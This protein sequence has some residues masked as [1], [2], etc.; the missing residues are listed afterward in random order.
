[1]SV[2]ISYSHDSIE[3]CDKVLNFSNKLR[4]E[5]IDTILDQ[6]EDAPEEG[7]PRWTETKIEDSDFVIIFVSEGYFK[8]I[9]NQ[10]EVNQG[11]GVKWEGNVIYQ[12]LYNNGNYNNKFIPVV[13]NDDDYMFIPKPLQ[14]NTFYNISTENGYNNLYWRLRNIH[15]NEKP[16]LGEL[17]P[18]P[19][20]K[21]KTQFSPTVTESQSNDIQPDFS[22]EQQ[23]L[24]HW[25][26]E[27][28]CK[29]GP[30]DTSIERA[31]A[32]TCEGLLAMKITGYDVIK[33]HLY[34][35]TWQQLCNEA[36]INGLSSKTLNNETVI[37]TSLLLLL[38][39][40]ERERLSDYE[41]RKF[42]DMAQHLWNARNEDYGW[43]I[44][45]TK[46]DDSFCSYAYT[47]WA[48]RA[49]QEYSAIRNSCD[50]QAFCHQVFESVADGVFPFFPGG[51]KRLI[52]TAMYLGLYYRMTPAWQ[53]EQ[54]SFD[55]VK[56]IEFIYQQFVEQNLQFEVEIVY[57]LSLLNPGAEK[58][59]WNHIV[60]WPVI[61]ALCL[62]FEHG[63]LT[64]ERWD[65][66]LLHMKTILNKNVHAVGVEENLTYYHPEGMDKS[67]IGRYTY[68]TAY[69]IMAL[70]Q[71]SNITQKDES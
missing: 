59:P 4:S 33:K 27:I 50:Y 36:T 68:P 11:K 55:K 22:R 47:A 10:V 63:D 14:G 71:L 40:A 66:L 2:F 53:S 38:G 6:Y 1:M 25:L 61:D 34:E 19:E 39:A 20:R 5:G 9:Y 18:L 45:V 44:Y 62:A 23:K 28:R 41:K 15:L 24:I 43:G 12:T 58:A 29:W 3:F 16:S 37:C 8:K 49:L 51:Q 35:R 30:L 56:S 67:R 60:V 52:V 31:H 64:P 70:N 13:F 7:W 17:R 21:R 57:G 69:L 42:D 65:K 26:T 46:M 48:L 54:L 32:N